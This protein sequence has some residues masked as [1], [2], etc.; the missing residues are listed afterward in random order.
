M[1]RRSLIGAAGA[2]GILASPLARAQ[3]EYPRQYLRWVVPYPAGG[4]TDNLARAVAESMR[5]GLQ[6]QLVIDNRPGASTNIG[7]EMVARAKPDGYT[8]MSA[9]NAVLAFNEHLFKSLRYSPE[10][11]FSYIGAI[12]RFPLA[13]V[14]TPDFPAKNFAEFMAYV[15]ANPDKVSYASAG[16]GSPHHLAMELFKNRTGLKLTHIPYKGAAPAMQDIMAGQVGAMFLDLASGLPI[17]QTGKVRALA[18]A[19]PKRSG[20]MPQLPTLDELGVK[21]AE[22]FAFQGMLG[23]AG[24]P[25]SIV[26]RLNTELRKAMADQSVLKKFT[27]FGF[28][29]L[30]LSPQE[31]KKLARAESERWGQVIRTSHIALE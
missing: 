20:V 13:L 6:Q 5:H 9:D 17:V 28:E 26:T 18:I 30:L 7:A 3:E 24:L 10:K 16:S 1:K 25:E 31:F 21:D 23:P 15:R 8:V 4:G 19:S 27:D 12:G 22:V 14:V 2:L 11:D 29:P